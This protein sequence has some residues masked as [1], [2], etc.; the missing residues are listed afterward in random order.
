MA[1]VRTTSILAPVDNS[2]GAFILV[3]HSLCLFRAFGPAQRNGDRCFS[4]LRDLG[5]RGDIFDPGDGET[6]F[7]SDEDPKRADGQ[8]S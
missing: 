3:N 1:V 7:G 5:G 2:L 4:R 6:L 8:N